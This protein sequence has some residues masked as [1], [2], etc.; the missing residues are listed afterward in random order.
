MKK[1]HAIISALTI[2]VAV[3]CAA[4]PATAQPACEKPNMMIVL[5]RSGS[6][7]GTKWTQA[8][9]AIQFVLNNYGAKLRFGLDMFPSDNDCGAGSI[10]VDV[11]DDTAAAITSAMSSAG[12]NGNTPMAATLMVLNQY[13]PL[14]DP[15]RRNFIMLVS[16]GD[17]T[18]AD[19]PSS[20]PVAATQDLYTTGIK[21]FV[22]GFGS[23]ANPT[24]LNN[25]AAAGHT[26]GYHQADNQAD[27]QNAMDQIINEALVELCDDKDNDCDAQIDEDWPLK[28]T[29]CE[30]VQGGCTGQGVYVCN[31]NQNGVICNAQIVATPEVCDGL[32]NDCDGVIDNGFPDLDGDTYNQCSDCCDTGN[33]SMAGCSAATASAIN[34]GAT[35]VCNGRDDNCNL[36]V[37][38]SFPGM[39]DDCGVDSGG[40]Q[41]PYYTDEGECRPGEKM[42]IGGSVECIGEVNPMSEINCDALDNDCDGVTDMVGPEVCDDG[43]DNDCD[44]LTD[45]WDDE[46][47]S[48]FPGQQKQCGT[49]EGDCEMGVSICDQDGAWGPCEGG[50]LGSEEVCDGRDNDCDGETDENAEP[51]ICD[52]G[53]DNDCDGLTDGQ[54]D[55]CGECNPGDT[56]ECGVDTGECRKGTEVCTPQGRWSDCAGE[57]RPEP[58]MCNSL[59][60]DCDGITD[61]GS[62][63]QGYDICL[64]GQCASPCSSGECPAGNLTCLGGWCVSDPCCGV[65][66]PAGEECDERGDCVDVCVEQQ[67]ECLPEEDCRMGICVP[68]D[69]FT[70]GHECQ[71]GNHCVEG[72]CEVDPC[73]GIDCGAQS[74][75]HDGECQPIACAD[76][77]PDQV[78]SEGACVESQ[79]AGRNCQAGQ[80]C[81]DGECAL[82]PC[83]GVYCPVGTACSDGSCIGDA[84][85]N[86]ECPDGSECS[87]G[88]CVA[89]EEEPDGGVDAGTDAGPDA[90]DAAADQGSNPDDGPLADGGADKGPAADSGGPGSEGCGCSHGRP[91]SGAAWL[92]LL[93][94]VAVAGK[95]RAVRLPR[96]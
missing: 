20:D 82:D 16:D 6:M 41:P 44:G 61:E 13:R 2:A 68:A 74:W 38:E 3:L 91:G 27:L 94:L 63:C 73:S 86:V 56:R 4:A 46:C 40:E 84:C 52:D 71:A 42:C 1:R 72:T 92:L 31:A 57:I 60:D 81:I 18:C 80:V 62:L 75:C 53:I 5:D 70:P 87:Q 51:E 32:D 43:V 55:D 37:D 85:Q 12:A 64:C 28:G 17:D 39:G 24:V 93:L 69:C 26:G 49:S 77:T 67:I 59:D 66:C 79:C 50:Y 88:Y 76:C 19:N 29:P 10:Q 21:T 8:Q 54:D 14:K 83:Q 22:I 45:L 35:E 89:V 15:D 33:E 23:G 7:Q 95:K 96:P 78:C 36:S 58:E 34:P 90:G 25:I 48:C 9:N 65:H 47:G 11:G 30:I